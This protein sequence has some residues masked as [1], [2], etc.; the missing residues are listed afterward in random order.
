M[1]TAAALLDKNK[2][3]S[4]AEIKEALSG[5]KCRCATHMGIMRAVRRAAQ[6][7]G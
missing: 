7:M 6:M 2:K 3:P 1:L 5:L 4:D